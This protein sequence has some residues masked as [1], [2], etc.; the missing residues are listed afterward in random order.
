VLLYCLGLRRLWRGRIGRGVSVTRASAFVFGWVVLALTLL[1]PPDRWAEHSLAAHVA[2]HM[3][4]MAFVPPLLLG[5]PGPVLLGLV[6]VAAARR[7]GSLMRRMQ[8]TLPARALSAPGGAMVAQVA[9]MWGWHVPAAMHAALRHEGIHW[10]MHA[11]FLGAGLW[12]WAGLL[13]SVREPR[14]GAATSA[15]AII[16]TMMSMGLLG[17]LMTFADAP[18]YAAYVEQAHLLGFDALQDQQLAGLIMWVPSALPYLLG[19][20]AIVALWLRV[21]ERLS[22]TP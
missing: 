15:L 18:H 1:G 3:L 4:L 16:G 7:L 2:Q 11:S 9:V 21:S 10:L 13:R 20:V 6:P 17:A 8:Q 12:F 14:C 19:G 22:P 5:L